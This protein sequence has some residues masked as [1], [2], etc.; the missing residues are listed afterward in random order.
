MA[1]S[2]G[3]L[4]NQNNDNIVSLYISNCVSGAFSE[5]LTGGTISRHV[6]V[7]FV[8]AEYRFIRLDSE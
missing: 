6:T 2:H 3:L 1:C 4:G 8:W 5:L 7:Q